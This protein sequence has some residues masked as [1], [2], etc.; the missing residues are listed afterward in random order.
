MAERFFGDGL[1]RVL[2]CTATLAWGVNLPAHTVVIKGTQARRAPAF[3]C[4]CFRRERRRFCARTGGRGGLLTRQNPKPPNTPKPSLNPSQK[5]HPPTRAHPPARRAQVYNAQK[6]AF[7]DLGMLDVQQIFGRAGRPQFDTSGEGIILTTHDKL[8]HYLGAFFWGV[9]HAGRAGKAGRWGGRKRCV[10]PLVCLSFVPV[11]LSPIVAA[12]P[13]LNP[14]NSPPNPLPKPPKPPTPPRHPA[15]GMLTAQL[16]IESK[17]RRGLV[18]NLNAEARARVLLC[19]ENGDSARGGGGLLNNASASRARARC[20]PPSL[21][22][23]APEL[24]PPTPPA[25][26]VSPP[27]HLANPRTL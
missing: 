5:L 17:F 8:A 10:P 26:H 12:C 9:G 23:A 25:S 1:I 11:L 15:A 22:R 2:V 3:S 7:T 20:A 19:W 27:S 13:P 18:D 6:G 16:P 21:S 4:L 24:G 14:P